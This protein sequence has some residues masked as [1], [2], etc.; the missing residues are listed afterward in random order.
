MPLLNA[1]MAKISDDMTVLTVPANKR[2]TNLDI[3]L[4]NH[5]NASTT[6]TVA[7]QR[8]NVDYEQWEGTIESR[9]SAFPV[10]RQQLGTGDKL[11]IK[12]GSGS[13]TYAVT[14]LE[15]AA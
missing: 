12:P 3:V 1:L 2:V 11:I 15:V 13:I 9:K 14:Q 10:L 8:S 6:V 7:F 5:G 4:F